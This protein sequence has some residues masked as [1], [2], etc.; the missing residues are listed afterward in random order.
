MDRIEDTVSGEGGIGQLG[1][2]YSSSYNALISAF[3]RL[4]RLDD[5][6]CEKI[7]SGFFSEVF[8]VRHRTSDQVMALK[9]NKLSSNRANMLKEVQLMNRLSHPNILRFMGVCV[10]QGQLHAL[11]EYINSGNLEQLLD[12]NQHLSWTVRVK[13][14]QD[15][16]LGLAYLHSKGIFHRD[17]TSK[18]CLIKSEEGGYSAIVA[19]FGLAE[20]IPDYSGGGDKLAVVGSP[21]W[22]APEVLR[23]EHY[24]ETADVFSYGI[25]LCE[26]IARIQA[27]PDYLPRTEN[28]GL[29]Y[30]S[31]QNMVGDCPQDFLQLTFNCCNMDPKLRPSFIDIVKQLEEILLRL[32]KEEAENERLSNNPEI[33]ET[34]PLPK[35]SSE[36]IQGVK[37]LITIPQDD[38]IPQ[39]SPRPRRN[40]T[41]SRSQSDVFARKPLR[42]INVQDPFYT[43]SK[44]LL[45]KVNPFNAREDLKGG[46]IKFFDMP[47]KSVI[48]HV[49]DLHSPKMEGSQT[50]GLVRRLFSQDTVDSCYVSKSRCRSLPVSPELLKRDCSAS[51][52]LASIFGKCDPLQLSSEVRARL[53]CNVKYGVSDIPPYKARSPVLDCVL[54][55]DMDYTDGFGVMEES[56]FCLSTAE[57]NQDE[58]CN[59]LLV[60]KQKPTPCSQSPYHCLPE[61][62]R[63]LGVLSSSEAME[64]EDELNDNQLSCSPPACLGGLPLLPVDNTESRDC[65]C[66]SVSGCRIRQEVVKM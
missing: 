37:R 48:S 17:L 52:A 29:D 11:T 19:D 50:T 18:N 60:S 5:F 9:M 65:L 62:E 56:P 66:D 25:I 15:L 41:L 43:P 32:R 8:K 57:E 40:I 38:K 64:I 53:L 21:Y 31:F 63:S 54:G 46:K 4:T 2:V 1:R 61:D 7:G 39:K 51:P 42:K 10:H 44:G 49:F 47:S 59:Q 24:N 28:F 6:T 16:A 36:K 12:S 35:G 45:R 22:M 27:D 13:L 58:Y 23:D 20:K 33:N 55:E 14:A 30:D 34:K 26:I 3:S